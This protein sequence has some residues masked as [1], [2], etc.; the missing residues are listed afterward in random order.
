ML[1]PPLTSLRAGRSGVVKFPEK[2][3]AP[4]TVARTGNEIASRAELLAIN[5]PP[6]TLLSRGMEMLA[7]SELATKANVPPVEVK[8]GAATS[9]RKFP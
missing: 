4:P 8:F 1:K 9:V 7:K 2:S 5:A 6:P 3:I